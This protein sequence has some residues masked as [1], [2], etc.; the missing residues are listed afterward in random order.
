[1][2]CFMKLCR[3]LQSLQLAERRLSHPVWYL[4]VWY[5]PAAS[6]SLALA[7]AITMGA[8]SNP[9]VA[10]AQEDLFIANLT[11][12]TITVYARTAQGD[13]ATLRTLAGS[14]TGLR[15]CPETIVQ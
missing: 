8:G 9:S 11:D 3:A 15:G 10:W 2:G 13:T 7:V 1:M 4:P 14:A 5:L 12:G 6:L